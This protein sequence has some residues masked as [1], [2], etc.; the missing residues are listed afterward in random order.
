MAFDRNSPD[1]VEIAFAIMLIGGLAL[2]A[3]LGLGPAQ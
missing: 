2:L 3:V 1:P